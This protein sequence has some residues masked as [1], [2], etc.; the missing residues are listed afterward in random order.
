MYD[1][2]K[3]RRA[4]NFVRLGALI[5][6]P[7]PLG[8]LVYSIGQFHHVKEGVMYDT[9]PPNRAALPSNW[10]TVDN[11]ILVEWMITLM[12]KIQDVYHIREMPLN[13][14]YQQKPLDIDA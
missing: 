14:D 13:T 12:R 1:K 6:V 9:T 8:D 11:Q 10:W 7:A 2:E 4:D 5:P 3:A